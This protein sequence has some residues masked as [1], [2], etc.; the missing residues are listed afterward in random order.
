M[1][2]W[3]REFGADALAFIVSATLVAVYYA[4]LMAR[5]RRDPTCTIHGLNEL[6]RGLWVKNVMANP[7][8][9]IM[10]VQTLRNFIMGASLM[11]TTAAFLI[12]GTLTLSGQAESIARSWHVFNL[13]GSSAAELWILKV[14]CLLADFIIAFFAFAMAIRL[15]NHVVFMVN[16]PGPWPNPALSPEGV[17]MRLNRAGN[18]FAIGMRAFL[19]AVPLVFWLF[20]PVFLVL[21]SVGLVVALHRLDRSPSA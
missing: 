6:A 11:A 18:H 21:A 12:V 15:A 5:A 7:A 19:F 13:Y 8:K 9:D 20:G 4:L 16:V 14:M 1:E 3:L 17:A 2:L 10:A